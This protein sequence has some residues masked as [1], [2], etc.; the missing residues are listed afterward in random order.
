MN[1]SV[2]QFGGADRIE[3]TLR[4]R[5]RRSNSTPE[6]HALAAETGIIDEVRVAKAIREL[7]L[8]IGENP[9]RD[10][11]RDTPQ[12]VARSFREI[13]GGLRDNA[14][15]HLK[16]RFAHESDQPVLVSGIDFSSTCEHHL[17]PFF[18][19]AHIAYL[20]AA[21]QVVGLSKLARTVEVFARRPQL[22]ERI[23]E[24]I[25]SAL[26]EH[27]SPRGACVVLEAEHMCMRIRGACKPAAWTTT[28]AVRGV[29]RE[30]PAARAEV[31]S[32][33]KARR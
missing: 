28:L 10:G 25:A 23:T 32:L 7:L 29:Y 33:M 9:D 15:R 5:G 19:K 2:V 18:G 26:D 13:F 24:Q 17:L 22:Q 1:R 11:L 31:L 21:G 6:S 14:H 8:A 20:P 12:R 16:T 4:L 27:L 30:D 3:P